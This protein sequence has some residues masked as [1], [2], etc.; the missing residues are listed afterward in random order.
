MRA[1]AAVTATAGPDGR[2]WLRELRSAAP[3]TLRPTAEALY[4]AASGAGPLGGD[5]LE[6]TVRVEPGAQL[7][8]RAVSAQVVLPGRGGE[9]TFALRL[10]V[11]DGG[12]LTVL[13]EPTIVATG[14]RYRAVV[15]ADLA[16]GASLVLREEILLGRS[17]ECGGVYRGRLRVT[18]GGRPLLRHDLELDGADPVTASAGSAIADRVVG[19]LLVVRPELAATAT[20]TADSTR[21]TTQGTTEAGGAASSPTIPPRGAGWSEVHAAVLP[22]AGPGLLISATSADPHALR[23]CLAD[24]LGS[25]YRDQSSAAIGRTA[26]SR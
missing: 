26:G 9:A 1:R 20:A 25:W 11:A 19:S 7:V 18:V 16:A 10:S 24:H 23:E 22:L 21:G 15:A 6:L 13:P 17:G 3:L 2:T 8:L 14:A 4:L 5:D 12:S